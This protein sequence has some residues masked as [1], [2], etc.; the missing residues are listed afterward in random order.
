MVNEKIVNPD[1]IVQQVMQ[2]RL[3]SYQARENVDSVLKRYNDL[4]DQLIHAV[5]L[6]KNRILELEKPSKEIENK[7]TESRS[8]K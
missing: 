1:E 4:I 5:G 8:E 7:A 6:M 2:E 3:S